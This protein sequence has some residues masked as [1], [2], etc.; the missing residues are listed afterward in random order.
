[1]SQAAQISA[2]F[3]EE[4]NRKPG[5]IFIVGC[6]RSGT[7]LLQSLLGANDRI[8]S[9]TESQF[10]FFLIPGRSKYKFS[11]FTT[12][13]NIPSWRALFRVAR[14]EGKQRLEKWLNDIA[15]LFPDIIPKSL[16]G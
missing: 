13:I 2:Q 11:F 10:F 3:F 7:T 1:M 4:P 5:R 14:P 15:G 9:F 12:Q 6:P 8:I 16:S